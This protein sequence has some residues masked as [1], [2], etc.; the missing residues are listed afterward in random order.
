MSD[1]KVRMVPVAQ[2][3]ID[4]LTNRKGF[5]ATWDECDEGIRQEI[6]DSI[7][8]IV[9]AAPS[10]GSGWMPIETAPKDGSSFLGV[11]G[12]WIITMHWHRIQQCFASCGPSYERIPAD[13]Q[14]TH[15]QPLP[16]PP[17]TGEN[18]D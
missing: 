13:E 16:P 8:S 10:A 5:D 2:A 15:W 9:A 14:P 12:H 7:A 11:S 1:D 3:I 6:L 17:T 18:N 4:N